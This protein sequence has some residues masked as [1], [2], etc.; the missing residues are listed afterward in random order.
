M[1]QTKD[2]TIEIGGKELKVSFSRLAEQANGSVMLKYGD[3]VLLG[4]AVMGKKDKMDLDFFPLTVEYEEKFYAAGKILGSRFVRRE[5]RPSE[6]AVLTGRMIDR[7]IRPLFD[8]RLRRDV[9][10]VATTLSFDGENDPDMLGLNAASLALATSDIPWDGPAAAVRIAKMGNDYIINP[11]LAQR[12]EADLDLFLAMAKG[13]LNMIDGE[14]KEVAESDVMHAMTIAEKE[15][16]RLIEFQTKIINEQ[17]RKKADILLKEFP[18]EFTTAIKDFVGPLL[19]GAIYEKDKLKRQDNLE[20]V[21]NDLLTHLQEKGFGEELIKGTNHLLEEEID[22]VVHQNAIEHDRRPDGRAMDEVRPLEI[23]ASVLPRAHGS[24]IFM[25]GNTQAFCVVTL[26]APGD[27]QI[28]EGM[29]SSTKRRFMLH[30]NF[31]PYSVGE[32]GP[33]RGPGRREIG[34]GALATKGI[35][36]MIPSKEVFPYTI[37]AVSEVLS[38]NG[39]SSMASTCGVSLA[40]MDAGVPLKEMVGGIAMG[41]MSDPSTGK[42][43]I[44]TDIQGPEDH[45]GDMDFKVSGTKNGVNAIQLDVKIDGL[46]LQMVEEV[47]MRAKTARLH[48]LGEMQKVLSEP[49]KELSKHAPR[50]FTLHIDPDKIRDVIG[51][52]GKVINDIIARTNTTIDIED[53]G[54]IYVTG[55]NAAQTEEAVSIINNITKELTVGEIVE[56]PVTRI[57]DFGALVE[58]LPGKEG[59]VHISELANRRVEKVTDVVNLGDRVRVKVLRIEPDGKIG[60]SLKAAQGE[61]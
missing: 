52:G 49:R 19:D 14:G 4:T 34:H 40:L 24:A 57:M 47:L 25:R 46:T 5:G 1:L 44:L 6:E 15:L 21:K 22:R 35:H 3:T 11:T 8:H 23:H 28:V 2:Y 51:S 29:E 33:F 30:Y 54:T 61:Q 55:T 59:M 31:P 16:H 42:Y 10:V 18:K 12:A 53:D 38:S 48:I 37:R 9:Q 27:E 13:K 36:A 7:S 32:T 39:S 58:V 43:K 26:G 50:I 60:L 56:G 45:Y 20:K 17:N 41:L